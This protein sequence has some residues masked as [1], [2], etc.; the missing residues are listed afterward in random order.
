MKKTYQSKYHILL[1][2]PQP[3]LIQGGVLPDPTV[4]FEIFDR[5]VNIKSGYSVPFGLRGTVVGIQK[6][7]KDSETMYDV[8]FDEEFPGGIIIRFVKCTE[9]YRVTG[10]Y[11]IECKKKKPTY[12]ACKVQLCIHDNFEEM[13]KTE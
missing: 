7:E 1:D 12:F 3:L 9:K 13:I 11:I 2:F 4:Q 6:G 5:I 8:I 10:T